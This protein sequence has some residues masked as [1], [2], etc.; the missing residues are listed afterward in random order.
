M[1]RKLIAMWIVSLAAVMAGACNPFPRCATENADATINVA[2][3]YRYVGDK[4][5]LLRGTITFEQQGNFVRVVNTTYDNSSD[6]ALE[7]AFTP[8]SGNRLDIVLVPRNGDTNYRAD[9]T[10]IF[11]EDGNSFCVEF[12]DTNGDAGP[13]GTYSGLRL[14]S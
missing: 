3:T 14:P 5:T 7:S 10:F 4:A 13:L 11:S 2:G 8:L 1:N 12:S 9:V 6:R